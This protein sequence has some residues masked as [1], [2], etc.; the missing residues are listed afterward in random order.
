MTETNVSTN[1]RKKWIFVGAGAMVAVLLAGAAYLFIPGL[2]KNK[3]SAHFTSTTGLYEGDEVRVLGVNVGKV[4][5]IEPRDR[6]TYVEMKVDSSV[7]IPADAKA[8]IIAQSLVSARFIQLTPVYSGGDKMSNGGEIP[9]EHTAVPV[10]WD[11]IKTELTKLSESLGPEGLDDQGSLGRFI[12][13]LGAN[14]EGNGDSIRKTLHELSDTM[15][16]LSEGRTDLFS[17]IRNLQAFVTALSSSN[18]QIVQF[19]G[20]LASVSSVLAN[21]SDELGIALSDLDLAVGDVQRFV[22]ENRDGLTESVERLAGVTQILADNRPEIEQVLHAG[23]TSL[24]NFYQIYKPATGSMTGAIALSNFKNPI[25]WI[26]G[27]IE[28]IRNDTSQNSA[29]LCKQYLGPVLSTMIGNYPG[30]LFNPV[31]G[32]QAFPDQLVYSP[33]GLET[34]ANQGQGGTDVAPAAGPLDGVPMTN[35]P[36]D[37]NDLFNVGGGN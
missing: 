3:I 35:V 2:G 8:L 27:S 28:G 15:H 10:E 17:T 1:P 32:V 18:Q 14:L 36:K 13:T 4:T 24:A 5:K 16:T 9:I 19:S 30:F 6:D 25:Q 33:P 31:A 37:L 7:S 12:D 34:A 26:C 20:N 11:E 21:S 23:P 29:D 22:K